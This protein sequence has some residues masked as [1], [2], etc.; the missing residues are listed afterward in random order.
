MAAL[1]L[2]SLRLHHL[3][4][5]ITIMIDFLI[6]DWDLCLDENNKLVTIDNIAQQVLITLNTWKGDWFYDPEFGVDY[7]KLS[8]I[9]NKSEVDF[10]IMQI[11]LE[12]EGVKSINSF[13]SKM[14]ETTR[15]Y[16]LR[17]DFATTE[18]LSNVIEYSRKLSGVN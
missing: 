11:I 3:F 6:K 14:N 9:K 8:A 10:R 1:S 15:F 5:W 2:G 4:N 13:K 12:V 18:S 16:S 17:V 7:L